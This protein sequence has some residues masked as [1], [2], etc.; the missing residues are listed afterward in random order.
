MFTF[1]PEKGER[2][3]FL[4]D[5]GIARME[6]LVRTLHRPSKKG[7]VIRP[8][9]AGGIHS[10]QVRSAPSWD[11]EAGLFRYW[12]LGVPDDLGVE[13]C[14]CSAFESTDGLHWTATILGQVSYR[15]STRNNF[16]PLAP[17]VSV[18]D[19]DDPDPMRRYKGLRHLGSTLAP[20]VSDGRT[21]RPLGEERV[22]SWDEHNLSLDAA[23]HTFIATVKQMGPHGRAVHLATSQDFEHW[24]SHGLIFHSDDLDQERGRRWIERR[25][26]DASLQRPWYDIPEKYNV[27]VYNMGVFRYES[28]Y[29]GLP[30]FF[31]RTGKVDGPYPG[32]SD[33]EISPESLAIYRRDGDWSGFHH[34]QVASSRD[35]KAWQRVG[36]REPFL[37]ASPLGAGAYDLACL[38]GP[39]SPVP[40]GDELW[41]YYTGIKQ[42][43][44]PPPARGLDRDSG[45]VCLA[46]LRR[47]GFVSLDA[48]IEGGRVTTTPFLPPPGELHL[49]ADA[50]SGDVIVQVCDESGMPLPGFVP[51][52][53]VRGDL[54]DTL[55]RWPQSGLAS[56]AGRPVSLQFS[57]RSARLYSY[58]IT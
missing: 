43:G 50:L 40:R 29:I 14:G 54:L 48:G 21:W 2:Q 24:A 36:E 56:L 57:L 1:Q 22:R 28:L 35:L 52:S 37:D 23:T 5:P 34:V 6:G 58:W 39:S 33:W 12:V 38:I 41:F 13:G 44:G 51:S 10:L 47:D 26:A 3:L 18:R 7:A 25:F 53:P 46:T 17:M 27:D 9:L 15:G 32:F 45:A 16:A 42:Y 31:Y 49:N 20:M 55:V 4:D 30:S 11:S 8:D 19:P